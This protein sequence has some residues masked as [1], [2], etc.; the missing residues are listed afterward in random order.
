[1]RRGQLNEPRN[2]AIYLVRKLRRDTL[3]QIACAFEIAN[4]STV[5]SVVARMKKRL[6]KRPG[7]V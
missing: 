2:M 6:E 3:G 7:T 4:D 1:M 5:S